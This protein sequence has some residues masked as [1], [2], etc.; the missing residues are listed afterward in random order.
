MPLYRKEEEMCVTKQHFTQN[1]RERQDGNPIKE[2][3]QSHLQRNINQ[4]H[5]PVTEWKEIAWRKES[6]DLP[7]KLSSPR[8]T[9]FKSP[10]HQPCPF[11]HCCNLLLLSSLVPDL[12]DPAVKKTSLATACYLLFA[13]EM[14]TRSSV[15]RGYVRHAWGFFAPCYLLERLSEVKFLL[16]FWYFLSLWSS[17]PPGLLVMK[18]YF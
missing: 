13:R 16:W 11:G 17:L 6:G 12:A 5:P 8:R 10:F 3:F 9:K 7:A 14:L 18:F 1:S 2:I 15:D 4:L